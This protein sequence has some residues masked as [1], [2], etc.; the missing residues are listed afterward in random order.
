M[1]TNIFI[2][3]DRGAPLRVTLSSAR[4][5][6]QI[7]AT[8]IMRFLSATLIGSELT[9]G[10]SVQAPIGW[11]VAPFPTVSTGLLTTWSV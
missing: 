11:K 1:V 4:F 5:E 7:S 2:Q 10:S 8:S 9:S 3:S 6:K